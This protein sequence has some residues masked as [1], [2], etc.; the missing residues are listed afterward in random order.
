MIPGPRWF[1]S[2][3]L[4][5]TLLDKQCHCT[6]PLDPSALHRSSAPGLLRGPTA[7]NLCRLC[8]AVP[9]GIQSTTASRACRGGSAMT[10][11]GMSWGAQGPVPSTRRG[12][13]PS[14]RF[15]QCRESRA[16]PVSTGTEPQGPAGSVC[17]APC[18]ANNPVSHQLLGHSQLR[19]LRAC[20]Q[21]QPLTG[22]QELFS[23]SIYTET[24]QKLTEAWLQKNYLIWS[25][26][27]ANCFQ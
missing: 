11:P 27:M 2:C 15:Q 26:R 19:A 1:M 25:E 4:A 5:L 8:G 23:L 20:V 13:E 14:W 22:I 6:E 10:V 17:V 7:L 18:L 9:W 24:F 3:A 16:E 21:E 12:P